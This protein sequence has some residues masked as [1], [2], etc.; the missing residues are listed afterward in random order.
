MA[1]L[2]TKAGRFERLFGITPMNPDDPNARTFNDRCVVHKI[3]QWQERLASN[4]KDMMNSLAKVSSLDPMTDGELRE[5]R[6]E[7]ISARHDVRRYQQLIAKAKKLAKAMGLDLTGLEV[8][9]DYNAT[10]NVER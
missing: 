10:N 6:R 3:A 4:S 8:Y 5:Y 9:G 2:W 1:F 7:Y